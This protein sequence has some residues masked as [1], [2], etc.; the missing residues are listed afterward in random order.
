MKENVFRM[1]DTN[2]EDFGDDL[3]FILKTNCSRE[4][5]EEIERNADIIWREDDL[6]DL[7]DLDEEYKQFAPDLCGISKIEIMEKI[8]KELGYIWEEVHLEEIEW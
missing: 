5:V 1:V 2:A 7:E 8:A 4:K 6:E 3:T